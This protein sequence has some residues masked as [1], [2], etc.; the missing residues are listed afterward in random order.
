MSSARGEEG[1]TRR[2]RRE[3]TNE[4]LKAR[5]RRLIVGIAIIAAVGIV[6]SVAALDTAPLGNTGPDEEIGIGPSHLQTVTLPEVRQLLSGIPQ[7]GNVLGD[8]KAPVTLDYIGDLQSPSCREFMLGVLP[9]LINHY[10]RKGKLMIRYRSEEATTR[11]PAVFREQQ[12]AA[13]AAGQ[14]GLMWYYV[15]LFYQTQGLEGSHYVTA[16]YLRGLAR[17][18]PGL[19]VAK[20]EAE[21]RSSSMEALLEQQGPLPVGNEFEGTPSFWIGRSGTELRPF[22]TDSLVEPTSFEDA[23][24]RLAE[25]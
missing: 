11:E 24:G 22:R 6:A 25:H 15:D 21:R 1:V 13:L 2:E 18:V 17:L 10:V 14:Q 8:P 19:D 3:R 7:A 12:E 20:W 16:A 4:G 9:A 23:I 5:R